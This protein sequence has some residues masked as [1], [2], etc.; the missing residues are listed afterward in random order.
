MSKYT[1]KVVGKVSLQIADEEK[2]RVFLKLVILAARFAWVALAITGLCFI[3][4]SFV[5]DDALQ[6][7][8]VTVGINLQGV[9]MIMSCGNVYLQRL[10]AKQMLKNAAPQ[11]GLVQSAVHAKLKAGGHRLFVQAAIV[12]V[13]AVSC[14][15]FQ[16]V[17]C[18]WPT[19][20]KYNSALQVEGCLVA[21]CVNAITILMRKNPSIKSQ[22]HQVR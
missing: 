20:R 4:A 5:G 3:T 11:E 1:E 9:F 2:Q 14:I 10:I 18:N 13:L 7:A 15:V 16:L 8:L 6:T 21:N 17:A 22:L 12:G 19:A